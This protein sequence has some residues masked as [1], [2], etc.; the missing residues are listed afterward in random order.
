MSLT[1]STPAASLPISIEDAKL[2]LK[3]DDND[4]DELIQQQIKAAVQWLQ[5]YTARQLINAT[6]AETFDVFS[7]CM[8]LERSPL[9]SVSSITYID[10]NGDQQT[11]SSSLYTVDTAKEPGEVRLAYDQ[12]WPSTRAIQDAVTVNYI[13]GYGSASSNVPEELRTI[14]MHKV[15][16]LNEYR[17]GMPSDID[18]ALERMAFPWRLVDFR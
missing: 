16:A 9:S 8:V 10:E 12:S 2:H 6:F 3:Q 11:A 5:D 14:L 7:D 15:A 13:S 1:V 18:H 17:F 4:E